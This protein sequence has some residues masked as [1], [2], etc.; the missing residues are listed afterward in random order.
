MSNLE[1]RE[2]EYGAKVLALEPGG[3]EAIP[4][5]ERHGKARN[6]FATWMSPNLEFATMFVGVLAVAVF[7]LSFAQAVLAIVI[8]NALGASAQFILTKMVHAMASHRWS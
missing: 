6:L 5:K 8:G 7:G 3:I 1:I 4:E 2:G